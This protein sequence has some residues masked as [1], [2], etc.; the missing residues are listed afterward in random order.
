MTAE[1]PKRHPHGAIKEVVMQAKM[2]DMS[3]PQASRHFQ[4][5]RNSIYWAA[6]R[7]GVQLK[8]LKVRKA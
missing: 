2:N 1:A 5:N 6:R 8:A 4:V 7:M 3:V